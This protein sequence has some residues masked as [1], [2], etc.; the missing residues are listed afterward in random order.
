MY[1]PHVRNTAWLF[2]CPLRGQSK[3]YMVRALTCVRLQVRE[4]LQHSHLS[5]R[6]HKHELLQMPPTLVQHHRVIQ[7]LSSRQ[8]WDAGSRTREAISVII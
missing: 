5:V 3:K 1:S 6:E 2:L 8:Q 4:C 7:T